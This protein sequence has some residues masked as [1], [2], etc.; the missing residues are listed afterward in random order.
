MNFNKEKQNKRVNECINEGWNILII[1]EWFFKNNFY[2]FQGEHMLFFGKET[3]K[4]LSLVNENNK[5][6]L[7]VPKSVLVKIVNN[8]NKSIRLFVG[9]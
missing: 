6:V 5:V 7:W 8:G 3:E 2:K 4:A 9:E 1:R